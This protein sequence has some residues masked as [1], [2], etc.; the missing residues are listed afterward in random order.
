VASTRP[1]FRAFDQGAT[2]TIACFN[3]ATTPLGVDLDALIAA[4]QAFVDEHV[5]PVWGTPA[6]LMRSAGF[7]KGAW[8]MVFLDNA[9]Q[10]GALCLS[11]S[12]A[13]R[14]FWVLTRRAQA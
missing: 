8:A 11:R 13:R 4:M 10:A 12:H 7:V 6:K 3:K 5:A 14:L 1:I 2:P 9:D